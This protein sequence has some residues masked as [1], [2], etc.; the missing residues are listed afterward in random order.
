MSFRFLLFLCCL[1][2]FHLYLFPHSNISHQK[3]QETQW[4]CCGPFALNTLPLQ[5]FLLNI[6]FPHFCL[7]LTWGLCCT[8]LIVWSV[9]LG[10]MCS[11][12]PCT[13]FFTLAVEFHLGSH[14]IL[15][16]W[17]YLFNRYHF[18]YFT[19]F[20]LKHDIEEQIMLFFKKYISLWTFKIPAFSCWPC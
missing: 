7:S 14:K 3:W 20:W 19:G 4:L 17:N 11:W 6:I 1:L 10:M 16:F 18:H 13:P 12:K 15:G 9:S 8:Q 5:R 2:L